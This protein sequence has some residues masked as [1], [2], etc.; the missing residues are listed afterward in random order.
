MIALCAALAAVVLPRTL[1]AQ[2]HRC[3][4]PIAQAVDASRRN[5]EVSDAWIFE[6]KLGLVQMLREHRPFEQQSL[7]V[8]SM[9][10]ANAPPLPAADTSWWRGEYSLRSSH[11]QTISAATAPWEK[12]MIPSQPD[13]CHS[14]ARACTASWAFPYQSCSCAH[15]AACS[16]RS[17]G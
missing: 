11:A 14:A 9:L 15:H 3:R 10:A 6:S 1:P 4:A 7:A 8:F 5:L 17:L 12:P 16:V 13:A 2:Q